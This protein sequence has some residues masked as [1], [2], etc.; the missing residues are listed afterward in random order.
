MTGVRFPARAGTFSFLHRIQTSSGVHSASYMT[1]N[2]VI[3]PWVKRAVR[4]DARSPPS[5]AEDRN[6]WSYTSTPP[7]DFKVW[8]LL[9]HKNIFTVVKCFIYMFMTVSIGSSY[10]LC[11]VTTVV[12]RPTVEKIDQVKFS[13]RCIGPTRTKMKFVQQMLLQIP[14]SKSTQQFRMKHT[15][16]HGLPVARFYS[17]RVKKN[18]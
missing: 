11:Y 18:A 17:L 12:L 3:S 8:Y 16:G 6:V 1:G 15:D 4:G 7:Y 5:S 13:L 2:G 10:T 9:K 14:Q